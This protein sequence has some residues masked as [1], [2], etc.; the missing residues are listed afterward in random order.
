MV[1]GRDRAVCSRIRQNPSGDL[2]PTSDRQCPPCRRIMPALAVVV[3]F[4]FIVVFFFV[5]I[6]IVV[7]KIFFFIIASFRMTTVRRVINF[8]HPTGMHVKIQHNAMFNWA[9]GEII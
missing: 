5:F 1:A 7:F 2:H 9:F 4:F 8:L 6:F 3:V